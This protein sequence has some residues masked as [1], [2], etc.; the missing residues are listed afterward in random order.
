V[1]RLIRSELELDVA[2]Q[3]QEI[4]DVSRILNAT[5]PCDL[6]GGAH[7]EKIILLCLIGIIGILAELSPVPPSQQ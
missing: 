7:M 5:V 3:L 1:I 4:V 2:V 6:V